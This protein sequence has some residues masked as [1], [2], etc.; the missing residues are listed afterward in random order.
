[1]YVK[2]FRNFFFRNPVSRNGNGTRVG[3]LVHRYRP[4][5]SVSNVPIGNAFKGRKPV[6]ILME[7]LC[8]VQRQIALLTPHEYV[9]FEFPSVVD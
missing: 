8:L 9:A 2:S 1:M 6:V 4:G 5:I 7:Q 3:L